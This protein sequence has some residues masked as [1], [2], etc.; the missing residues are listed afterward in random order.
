MLDTGYDSYELERSVLEEAGFVL[1]IY[2]GAPDDRSAKIKFAQN[3]VGLFCRWSVIDEELLNAATSLKAVVRYGVGYDSVNVPAATRKGVKVAIVP[4]CVENAVAEHALALIF[5]CA[6]SLC[7]GRQKIGRLF[8]NAPR[9]RLWELRDKTLG[10]IGLGR[11]GGILC[12]KGKALFRTVLAYDPYV[13]EPRFAEVGA[14][15]TNLETLLAESHVISLHCNLTAET[16][17]LID[18]QA[19]AR[20]RQRP[21]LINTARGSV[22]D[23]NALLEAL[24]KKQIHSAGLDVFSD[25][26]PTARLDALLSHP[27]VV[28]TG[29]YAWYSETALPRLQKKAAE[30][31]LALL[32]GEKIANCLN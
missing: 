22:V 4:G 5:A 8:S 12:A 25:E 20:M 2:E 15:P 13:S 23:E 18:E 19:I 30:S 7:C 21:I 24:Q 16:R 17:S 27:H 28:V 26:P 32:R 31:M 29:H 6:R 11:I 3:A 9:R 10:I 14:V 1:D